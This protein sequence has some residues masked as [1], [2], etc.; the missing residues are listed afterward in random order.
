MRK[1]MVGRNI[2]RCRETNIKLWCMSKISHPAK[3]PPIQTTE[4]PNKPWEKIG[5][6]ITGP[7]Q[8]GQFCLV[9]MDYFSRY[10]EVEVLQSITSTTII[11]RLIKIFAIHGYPNEL[12]SD[13]GRQFISE[14]LEHFLSENGIKHRKVIPYWPRANGLVEIFN[15]SLKKAIQSACLMKKNWKIEIYKFLLNYR[16]TPQC[17]TNV[18]PCELLFNR[19]VRNKLPSF[20]GNSPKHVTQNGCKAKICNEEKRRQACWEGL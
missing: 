9:L 2:Q 16:T 14:E 10:P 8:G 3:P 19:K 1:S 15:K 4:L 12:V 7:F 17:T 13:N 5:I 20:D 11:K 18:P 6:D